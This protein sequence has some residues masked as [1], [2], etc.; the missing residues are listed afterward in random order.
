[1]LDILDTAGQEEYSVMRDQYINSGQGF[2]LVYSVTAK[3]SFETIGEMKDK[4][5]QSKET[6]KFPMVLCGNK[7]DL[8]KER[9]VTPEEG[10]ELAKSWNIPFFE[11]SAKARIN[12]EESFIELVKLV[13]DF[14]ESGG[15]VSSNA[16]PTRPKKKKKNGGA[17][18]L[19]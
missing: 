12:I 8:E 4:I 1:M 15:D 13:R 2:L 5:L 18:T 9:K 10:K 3:R 14:G 7:C 17:C 6:D 19:L 11:T 16:T